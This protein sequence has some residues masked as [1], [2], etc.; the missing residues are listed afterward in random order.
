MSRIVCVEPII[1]R[2]TSTHI[3]TQNDFIHDIV[4]ELD[5]HSTEAYDKR[6]RKWADLWRKWADLGQ[7]KSTVSL[8]VDFM[9]T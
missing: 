8:W 2:K 6:W 7:L 9:N 5:V 1:P 4:R 3:A